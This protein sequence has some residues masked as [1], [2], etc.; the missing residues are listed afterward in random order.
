MVHDKPLDLI[1]EAD[2]G[3]PHCQDRNPRFLVCLINSD[4]QSPQNRPKLTPTR[5]KPKTRK[6][7]SYKHFRDLYPP[8]PN[9]QNAPGGLGAHGSN[10]CTPTNKKARN[11]GLFSLSAVF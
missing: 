2:Q 9:S 10:P 5:T 6:P 4:Q 3:G 7:L 1:T 8:V 11:R